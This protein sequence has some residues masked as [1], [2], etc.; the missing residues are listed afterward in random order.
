LKI[1]LTD[2]W[3]VTTQTP[4][5]IPSPMMKKSKMKARTKMKM[6]MLISVRSRHAN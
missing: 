1:Y 4:R 2:C 5:M 6:E 3:K